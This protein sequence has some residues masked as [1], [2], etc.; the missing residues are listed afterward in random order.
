MK[1]IILIGAAL[2]F[3]SSIQAQTEDS[4]F[5][6]HIA[7]EILLNS[8]AYENLRVITKQIGPRL[9]GSSQMV[10]AEQW[11]RKALQT[12]GAEKVWLQQCVVPHWIRGGNDAASAV[13]IS[14]TSKRKKIWQ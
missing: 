13:Y 9:T 2:G 6:R 8:K 3:I 12:A 7:N 11:G 4:V 5:I 14:G 10:K 1:K